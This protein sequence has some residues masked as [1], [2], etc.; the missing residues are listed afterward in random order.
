MLVCVFG[1]G[2]MQ[3][4]TFDKVD[5]ESLDGEDDAREAWPASY[6]PAFY[7]KQIQIRNY[8]YTPT[9]NLQR[10]N[11]QIQIYKYIEDDA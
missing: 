9:Y 2:K 3:V 10:T 1:D 5:C 8:K 7:T 4:S 6:Q 11:T